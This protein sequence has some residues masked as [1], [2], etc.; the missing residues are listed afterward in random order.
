MESTPEILSRDKEGGGEREGE[1]EEGERE[2]ET[3][4]RVVVMMYYH[5]CAKREER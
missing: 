4:L 3:G 2:R 1:G 5:V